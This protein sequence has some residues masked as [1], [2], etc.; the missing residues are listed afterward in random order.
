MSGMRED[1][2]DGFEERVD[3][4]AMRLDEE[5]QK[6]ELIEC[7]QETMRTLAFVVFLT[8]KNHPDQ[9]AVAD[10]ERVLKRARSVLATVREGLI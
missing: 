1:D 10:I 8:T 7:L 5:E 6:K 3:K 9:E 4:V 2:V